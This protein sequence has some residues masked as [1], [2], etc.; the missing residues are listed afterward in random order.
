MCNKVQKVESS[1]AKLNSVRLSEPLG[2]A[3]NQ[4]GVPYTHILGKYQRTDTDLQLAKL[5]AKV[6]AK[7]CS[8]LAV[9]VPVHDQ[10]TLMLSKL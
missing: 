9:V 10:T 1:W 7:I 6:S 3:P 4:W 5:W 2:A 8:A